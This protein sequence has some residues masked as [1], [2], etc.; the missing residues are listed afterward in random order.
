MAFIATKNSD[1]HLNEIRR[2][3][4]LLLAATDWVFLPDSKL[5]TE[6][7]E[8]VIAY[9]EALRDC[10]KASPGKVVALPDLESFAIPE[11]V[12]AGLRR[13]D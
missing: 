2:K 1:Q 5:S 4:G 3:R 8:Q 9:R 6:E 11:R 12:K 10:T 13:V 7:Q